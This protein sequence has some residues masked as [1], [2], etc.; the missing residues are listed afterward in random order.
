MA[1]KFVI[2]NRGVKQLASTVAMRK[3]LYGRAKTA[4]EVA[5]YLAAAEAIDTGA[6]ANSIDG[7]AGIEDGEA[8]GRLFAR[9]F[10]ANWIEFGTGEPYPTAAH[11]ILRRALEAIGARVEGSRERGELG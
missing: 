11:A 10:K 6:Y 3:A 4:A 1:N 9:D 2:D 5:R 8:L 7:T